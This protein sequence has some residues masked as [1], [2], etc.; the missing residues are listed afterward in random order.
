MKIHKKVGL[1]LGTFDPI[2]NGHLKIAQSALASDLDQV[3]IIPS[4]D[5]PHKGEIHA[6]P[7]DRY[8]MCKDAV[9]DINNIFVSDILIKTTIQGYDIEMIRAIKRQYPKDTFYYILGSDVFI[10]ILKWQSLDDLL[11]LVDFKIII[12]DTSHLEL[13]NSIILKLTNHSTIITIDME[14]ISSSMIKQLMNEGLP[15]RHLI[16]EKTFDY[17]DSHQLYHKKRA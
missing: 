4:Y 11:S 3:M 13:V 5:A 7:N 10:N 2:H 12:R 16:Q 1:L 17:I 8:Q 15:Y 9:S 14:E 6:S